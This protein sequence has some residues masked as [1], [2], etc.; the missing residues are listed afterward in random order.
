MFIYLHIYF[1]YFIFSQFPTP[2]ES[3][4]RRL[5]WW[6]FRTTSLSR[7]PASA[8]TSRYVNAQ[9]IDR[10][11][12]IYLSIYLYIDI[13]IFVY[14]SIYQCIN[15]YVYIYMYTYRLC[16]DLKVSH[17][18]EC[19]VLILEGGTF[20]CTCCRISNSNLGTIPP[21]YGCSWDTVVHRWT[22]VVYMLV[23]EWGLFLIC[24]LHMHTSVVNR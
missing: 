18:A 12:F 16:S 22:A 17:K 5:W 13:D 20:N 19:E 3:M 24:E 9:W 23:R 7:G 15:I 14:T 21:G 10:S 6:H 8:P 1:L 4:A 11:M 2:G